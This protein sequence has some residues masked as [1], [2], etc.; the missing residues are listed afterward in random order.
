MAKKKQKR[1][2]VHSSR[3]VTHVCVYE[4]GNEECIICGAD[5][6]AAGQKPLVIAKP[7]YAVA[8]EQLKQ[9]NLPTS[10]K[11]WNS[12]PQSARLVCVC[13]VCLG[14]SSGVSILAWIIGGLDVNE[15]NA[16][17]DASV[18]SHLAN[19]TNHD[20]AYTCKCL[21]GYEGTGDADVEDYLGDGGSVGCV[22]INEC[23]VAVPSIPERG[24]MAAAPPPPPPACGSK[25]C[26]NQA[27]SYTCRDP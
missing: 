5:S 18:C 4:V 3:N 11:Q 2:M 12:K 25:V 23:A 14:L 13:L 15:C 17:G 20:D 26:V 9:A 16:S 19:C 22:D 27:G 21:P 6:K 1:V 10:K 24:G 7:G 8:A